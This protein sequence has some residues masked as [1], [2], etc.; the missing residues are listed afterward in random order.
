[1]NPTVYILLSLLTI[2]LGYFVFRVAV[3]RD[4]QKKGK[5]SNFA[6]FLEFL[7]FAAH[8]NLSYTFLPAPYPEIPSLPKSCAQTTIGAGIMLLGLFLTLWTMNGLGFQKALGQETQT[9]NRF[10]FYQYTRNPQILFY[11]LSIIGIAVLWPSFYALGWVFVYLVIAHMMVVTEEEHLLRIYKDD[12]EKYCEAVPR[13][14][15]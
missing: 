2:A 6:T 12:Y 10:G 3:R 14:I 1:M 11:G 4:Y 13:Y 8:A 15:W 7:I 5:L 9:L